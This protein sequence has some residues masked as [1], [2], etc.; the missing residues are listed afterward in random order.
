[1][2]YA[3]TECDHEASSKSNLSI[4]VQSKHRGDNKVF[5]CN[6]CGK[7]YTRKDHLKTHTNN[8]HREIKYNCDQCGNLFTRKESYFLIL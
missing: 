1:M 7:Q 3:C 4:H 5:G 2:K 6:E 8:V